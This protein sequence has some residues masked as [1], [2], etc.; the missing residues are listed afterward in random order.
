LLT[1]LA[2]SAAKAIDKIHHQVATRPTSGDDAYPADT[3]IKLILDNHSD[4]QPTRQ[5]V[6]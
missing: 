2:F 4:G 1:P 3:A 6:G 5:A